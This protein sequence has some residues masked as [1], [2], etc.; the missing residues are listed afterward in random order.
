MHDDARRW[1]ADCVDRY[2]LD[3]N[4]V[5]V[6]D[7]GGRD[8][9]GTT[10]RLWAAPGRYVVVDLHPHPSVDVVVDAADLSL[11]ERFDV[12]TS[13]ECLEHARRAGEVVATAWRHLRPGGVFVGTAAG[14]GRRPHGQHGAS[15]PADGEWYENVGPLALERWLDAAGFVEWVVDQQGA[16]I[17]WIAWRGDE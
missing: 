10:R 1:V 8:V 16:D 14:P 7:L 4:G 2:G 6:L 3:E 11:D 5:A 17:R 12:A 9:N 13:T 15:R